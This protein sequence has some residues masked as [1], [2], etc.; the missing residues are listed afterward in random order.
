MQPRRTRAVDQDVQ[1]A[2]NVRALSVRGRVSCG[3]P[4]PNP[5]RLPASARALSVGAVYP[6][7]RACRLGGSVQARLTDRARCHLAVQPC[8]LSLLSTLSCLSLNISHRCQLSAVSVA[9]RP[10]ILGC[11]ATA[12]GAAAA[13]AAATAAAAA[14][15][16]A[17]ATA[18]AATAAA[19]TA[20]ND[21]G[22][23]AAAAAATGTDHA[24][25][26]PADVGR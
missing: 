26:Q 22:A 9:A 15:T 2:S 20:A 14:A 18:A 17:A 3:G 25:E 21:T 16:A 11:A 4:A 10:P 12:A 8:C 5:D 1:A 7:Q 19:A 6:A 23:A 24:S 13:T